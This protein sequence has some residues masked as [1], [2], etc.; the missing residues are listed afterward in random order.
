MATSWDGKGNA[1]SK[2]AARQW[3]I[4]QGVDPNHMSH[5]WVDNQ[6]QRSAAEWSQAA[7]DL[8]A[9]PDTRKNAGAS[10]PTQTPQSAPQPASA[11]TAAASSNP[12]STTN[13][14][15]TPKTAAQLL[16]EGPSGSTS[17]GYVL[18]PYTGLSGS[19]IANQST[20]SVVPGATN[21]DMYTEQNL[22]D[23]LG[24]SPEKIADLQQRMMNVGL[25][26]KQSTVKGKWNN[27]DLEAYRLLLTGAN[28]AGKT[29]DQQLT[30]WSIR[31]PTSLDIKGL[32][33]PGSASKAVVQLTNPTDVRASAEAVSQS[34]I[35]HVDPGFVNAAPAA[36]NAQEQA[37]GDAQ[38]ADV[39]AGQG[40]TVTQAPSQQ[41]FLQ[42][43]LQRE[44]PLAVDAN[45]FVN[46]FD[47]F[48]KMLGP[49]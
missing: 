47:N 33:G 20:K 12:G 32:G 15:G 14:D 40:G 1:P 5:A 17:P 21:P 36:F 2:E 22:L 45:S 25:Y 6:D 37:A 34:L 24:W 41:A 27:Q 44:Q 31:P 4:S 46:T 35:G 29:S 48:R 43:K 39:A 28:V 42:D 18:L 49:Q 10:A 30:E 13:A 38:V 3:A 23:P 16:A 26:G 7:R 9:N 11:P 19:V 8:V